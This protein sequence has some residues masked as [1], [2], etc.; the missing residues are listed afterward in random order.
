MADESQPKAKDYGKS[1]V[2]PQGE[3]LRYADGPLTFVEDKETPGLYRAD[4]R[5]WFKSTDPPTRN[6]HHKSNG[7]RQKD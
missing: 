7:D 6:G 3:P 5:S 1:F 2:I 4:I